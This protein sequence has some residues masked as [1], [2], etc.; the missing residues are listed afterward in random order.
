[1]SLWAPQE[2]VTDDNSKR[3]KIC[4]D[5]STDCDYSDVAD[6]KLWGVGRE[7][8]NVPS[9]AFPNQHQYK[10]V[11]SGIHNLLAHLGHE[12]ADNGE[13]LLIVSGPF[14]ANP[15]EQ[16]RYAG[17]V[18]GTCYSPKVARECSWTLP[19]PLREGFHHVFAQL[20]RYMWRCSW[21]PDQRSE[22]R[23]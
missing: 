8:R 6:Y 19:S 12:M 15:D 5:A 11:E 18:S 21:L 16:R 22:A 17:I 10:L 20:Q 4:Q 9:T 23:G 14:L 7:A 1:M 2:E 13:L 3:F